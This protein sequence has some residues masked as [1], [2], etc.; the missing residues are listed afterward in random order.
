MFT[1]QKL[2]TNW[3]KQTKY[4]WMDINTPNEVV[5]DHLDV[6]CVNFVLELR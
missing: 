4:P 3:E 2:Y 5:E 6:F 1:Q